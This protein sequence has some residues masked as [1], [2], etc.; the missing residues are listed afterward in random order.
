MKNI[1]MKI[2]YIQFIS[3]FSFLK[4]DNYNNDNRMIY[5]IY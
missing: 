5:P 3:P 1:Q 2:L 4:D